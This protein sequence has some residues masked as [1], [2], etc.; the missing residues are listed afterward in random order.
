MKCEFYVTKTFSTK[1]G[2]FLEGPSI[3]TNI[4]PGMKVIIPLNNSINLS[5]TITTIQIN[6]NN[7]H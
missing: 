7:K 5:A 1:E 2:I 6:N 4:I 3:L